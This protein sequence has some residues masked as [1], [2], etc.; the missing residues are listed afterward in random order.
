MNYD[1]EVYDDDGNGPYD[2][3]YPGRRVIADRGKVSVPLLLM[4]AS[5]RVDARSE[6]VRLRDEAHALMVDRMRFPKSY[7]AI[8]GARLV[9][10]GIGADLTEDDAVELARRLAPIL[11]TIVP[12]HPTYQPSQIRPA[13]ETD[14]PSRGDSRRAHYPKQ[15]RDRAA[16]IA[17][18]DA[19]WA[20]LQSRN[21]GGRHR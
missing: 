11:G 17:A 8:T 7:D 18:R 21:N 6:G 2:P 19:A 14:P 20:Q 10:D 9:G 4:D 3:R 13:T 5:P 1:S 12:D 15:A 16:G